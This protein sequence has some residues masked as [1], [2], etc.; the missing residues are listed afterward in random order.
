MKQLQ[1][2]LAISFVV[3]I[4]TG[5]LYFRNESLIQTFFG[6]LN[7]LLAVLI[8]NLLGTVLSF[9]LF[10][11]GWFV[12]YKAGNYKGFLVAAGLAA[13][14]GLGIIMVDLKV[15]FPEDV[16]RP[17]PDSLFFYLVFG[18]VVEVIFH[19][20]PLALLLVLIIGLLHLKN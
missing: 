1:I 3:A 8:I 17:F 4:H 18:Y 16:N 6:K 9:F 13:L 7:P 11:R 19:M 15:I 10:S 20:L 2:F 14:L 5:I 12:V